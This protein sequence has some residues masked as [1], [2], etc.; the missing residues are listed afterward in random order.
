MSEGEDEVTL[1]D[2]IKDTQEL[3]Q[4][5]GAAQNHWLQRRPV[6]TG[7]AERVAIYCAVRAMVRVFDLKDIISDPESLSD[8]DR[9]SDGIKLET[10]PV[11][12]GAS[13]RA[14]A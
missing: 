6:T 10:S 12:P 9:L 1:G 8:L 7:L 13:P 3:L 4:V 14:K 11:P 2:V 5:Y